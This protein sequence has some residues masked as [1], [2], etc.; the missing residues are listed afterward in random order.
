MTEYKQIPVK[1]PTEAAVKQ[2]RR[3]LSAEY[4]SD[5]TLDETVVELLDAYDG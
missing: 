2:L 5:V 4:E 3:E 1:E